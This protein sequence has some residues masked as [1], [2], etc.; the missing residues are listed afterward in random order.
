V[1]YVAN[2]PSK[3]LEHFHALREAKS[4]LVGIAIYD[5]LGRNLPDDP[6]LAQKT[7]RR[8]ELE[9]Y[10]C[11]RE[12]LLRFAEKQGRKLHGEIF[13][14]MWRTAM[15]KAIEQVESALQTLG[16]DPW[17]ADIKASDDFLQPL[18]KQ[19]YKRLDL[20][21]LMNKTDYHT[22]APH[23]PAKAIDDEIGKMLDD[24]VAAGSV[25]KPR[26]AV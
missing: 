26:E 15:E 17:G 19:F 13:V 16:N 24:I 6:R 21:N 5:R 9:N 20:P 1:H 7:W 4:D 3:A 2:Q 11:Q 25:A 22:L 18:F 10:L 12:T 8:R 14:D 23:V